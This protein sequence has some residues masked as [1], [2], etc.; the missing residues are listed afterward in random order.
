MK[1]HHT[2]MLT[3]NEDD[4]DL[5]QEH[6]QIRDIET[7]EDKD[8]GLEH[9][10][11]RGIETIDGADHPHQDTGQEGIAL[12]QGATTEILIMRT[13]RETRAHRTGEKM[14]TLPMGES[15]SYMMAR[16]QKDLET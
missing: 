10:I 11:E 5:G 2:G 7:T 16:D 6:L 3:M 12:H 4:E 15:L 14:I 13:N 8:L 1:D 9:Q